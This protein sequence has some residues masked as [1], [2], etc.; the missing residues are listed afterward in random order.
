MKRPHWMH[1][2]LY[3]VHTCL[4]TTSKHF[5]NKD[6]LVSVALVFFT[7]T[8]NARRKWSNHPKWWSKTYFQPL[9]LYPVKVNPMQK[10]T[11]KTFPESAFHTAL[12]WKLLR[13]HSRGLGGEREKNM[14]QSNEEEEMGSRTRCIQ[15]R[16]AMKGNAGPQPS[17]G[18]SVESQSRWLG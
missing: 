7:A 6:T 13:L 16:N 2:F 5:E 4:A 17:R 12:L 9:I 10:C 14:N 3:W 8:L 11:V 15:S 18:L 1:A